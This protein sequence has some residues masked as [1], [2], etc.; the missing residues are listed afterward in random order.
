MATESARTQNLL[1]NELGRNINILVFW[2][3]FVFMWTW[4]TT[5]SLTLAKPDV[6]NAVQ[7]GTVWRQL[8]AI[9]VVTPSSSALTVFQTAG[10]DVSAGEREE[11]GREGLG[12]EKG[13]T[14]LKLHMHHR[15]QDFTTA[16]LILTTNIQEDNIKPRKII[17]HTWAQPPSGKYYPGIKQ[18]FPTG[19]CTDIWTTNREPGSIVCQAL[20]YDSPVQAYTQ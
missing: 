14:K 1:I 9:I 18:L 11:G 19:H 20:H 16:A 15:Q 8:V 10:A 5:R 4:R 7:P 12:E 13:K 2:H 6:H 3:V 17:R